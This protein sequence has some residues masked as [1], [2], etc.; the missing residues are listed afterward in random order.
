MSVLIISAPPYS[1][2]DEIAALAAERLGYRLVGPE[3]L[4]A[5]ASQSG[6]PSDELDRAIHEPASW[7]TMSA[8]DRT[9]RLAAIEAALWDELLDGRCVCHGL[10]AHLFIERISHILRV[11]LGQPVEQRIATACEREGLSEGKARKLV[12][13]L[14]KQRRRWVKA[15]YR[16]DESDEDLFD[17]IVDSGRDDSSEAVEKIV[18]LARQRRFRPMSYSRKLAEDCA[19]AA[20]VRAVVVT[21]EPRAQVSVNEGQVRIEVTTAG[22]AEDLSPTLVEQVREVAGVTDVEV[23]VVNDIIAQAAMSMR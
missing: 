15:F 17:L 6:I 12:L 16:V 21:I 7:R 22:G 11:R 4:E 13:G 10:S 9:V 14:D 8:S 19:L 3:V 20:K 23:S 5:A 1:N 18:D 2:G